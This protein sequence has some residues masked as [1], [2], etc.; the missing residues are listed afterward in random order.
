[1]QNNDNPLTAKRCGVYGSDNEIQKV[2]SSD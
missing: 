1:M 2:C